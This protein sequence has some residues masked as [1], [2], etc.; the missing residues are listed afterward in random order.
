MH[1]KIKCSMKDVSE[2]EDGGVVRCR[3]GPRFCSSLG[4]LDGP[5]LAEDGQQK[6]CRSLSSLAEEQN[7]KWLLEGIQYRTVNK[8]STF[9]M[10]CDDRAAG[11]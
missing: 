5:V 1:T 8:I 2:E 4:Y 9:M 3:T 10:G 6:R 7:I 11:A